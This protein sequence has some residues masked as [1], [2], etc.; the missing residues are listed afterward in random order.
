MRTFEF[1]ALAAL[2]VPL[3]RATAHQTAPPLYD[4]REE[5]RIVSSESS[6]GQS[7]TTVTGLTVLSDGSIVTFHGRRVTNRGSSSGSSERA[8]RVFD[9]TGKLTSYF[10]GRGKG[11]GEFTEMVRTGSIGDTLWGEDY[12]RI[13]LF[14]RAGQPLRTRPL[15]P[16]LP[17]ASETFLGLLQG[18]RRLLRLIYS[19]R[20]PDPPPGGL[21]YDS[22]V[23]V[24]VDSPRRP[25]SRVVHLP[26]QKHEPLRFVALGIPTTVEQ[27]LAGTSLHALAPS[28]GHFLVAADAELWGGRPGQVRALVGDSAGRVTQQTLSFPPRAVPDDY[29]E[30]LAAGISTN[31]TER[32]QVR[33]KVRSGF[34]VPEFYPVLSK[35]MLGRDGSIWVQPLYERDVWTVFV[36]GN[37]T[38]RVR[39]PEGP[40]GTTVWAVSRDK[41]WATREDADGVPII[42]RYGLAPARN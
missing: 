25:V 9:A 26:A 39:I 41:V 16:S 5:L 21:P 14:S 30:T 42:L 24:V 23:Y 17:G 29:A 35:I 40:N 13:N 38:M 19:P 2:W 6:R 10:G 20:V 32:A 22:V 4:L 8:V 18:G 34:Y 37:A 31:P 11:P 12:G 33:A 28:G 3:A 27:R 1:L 36:N 15:R 7:L